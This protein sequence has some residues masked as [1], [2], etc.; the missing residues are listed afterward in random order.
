MKG[1]PGNF[2]ENL[3]ILE[4]WES[5]KVGTLTIVMTTDSCFSGPSCEGNAGVSS[6]NAQRDVL[7][8]GRPSE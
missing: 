6:K 8:N 1:I 5:G 3:E 2:L 7:W 4:F